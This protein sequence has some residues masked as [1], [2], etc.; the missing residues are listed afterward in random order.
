MNKI[1]TEQSR[2]FKALF[3]SQNYHITVQTKKRH[4]TTNK[5]QKT[6]K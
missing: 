2:L 6:N 4:K 1:M 3:I 5:K